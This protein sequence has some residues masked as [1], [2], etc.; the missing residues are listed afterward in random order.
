MLEKTENAELIEMKI[1]KTEELI[2]MIGKRTEKNQMF[3][4]FEKRIGNTENLDL[5]QSHFH[6]IV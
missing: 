2:G 6:H 3:E 1:D 5:L 4:M